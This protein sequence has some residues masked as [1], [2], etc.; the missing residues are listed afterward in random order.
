MKRRIAAVFAADV[1]G[2][3]QLVAE[4]EEETLRRLTS[5]K[6][7][8]DDFIVRAGG[9]VFKTDD[10]AILAEFSS[11]VEAMRCA[12]DVQESLRGRNM[13]YPPSRHMNY[14]IGIT[15]DD[16][17]DHEGELLGDG[18]SI[19]VRLKTLATAGG[20]CI[21]RAIHEQVAKKLSVQFSDIGAQQIEDISVPVYAYAVAMRPEDLRAAMLP[22]SSDGITKRSNWIWSVTAALAGIIAIGG[23]SFFY[24]SKARKP[25]RSIAVVPPISTPSAGPT[26]VA[27]ARTEPEPDTAVLPSRPTPA[28]IGPNEKLVAAAIPL[29]SDKLRL[30]I[31]NDYVPGGDYK[32]LAISNNQIGLVTGQASADEAKTAA[33]EKCRQLAN[34]GQRCD[35]YAVGN[36]VIYERGRAPLPPLPW[37]KHDPS[38]EK[39]FKGQDLPLSNQQRRDN[40]EKELGSAPKHMALVFGPKGEY[41]YFRGQTSAE[42][43]V[44]RAL[45]SCGYMVKTP[46]TVMVVD[47]MFVVA[48]PTT[49]KVTGFF[50]SA[51]TPSIRSDL[52]EEVA[53]RLGRE[54]NGWNVV[55]VGAAGR[56]GLGLK[57]ISE[58]D[59]VDAAMAE[60]RK[61]DTDCHVIAV[62]PFSV[63]LL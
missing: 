19:A 59:A 12:I 20:I 25:D 55:A 51:R 58:Q 6:L 15:M 9:R 63:D 32:A 3:S 62:V 24:F 39:P 50:D 52:R 41:S 16:L 5:Y 26:S 10:H 37:I 27:K 49:V 43:A 57:K 61:Q 46:C 42:E 21:S 11:A 60:C 18:V 13:A 17:V 1:S 35:I 28:P 33:L 8:M 4:D 14:R 36:A 7:V 30:V 53:R 38:V 22:V 45:E 34:A 31:A 2:Y 54:S 47:G 44:R 48:L 23:I 40:L 29:I 56:P